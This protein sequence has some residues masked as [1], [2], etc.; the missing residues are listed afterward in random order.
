MFYNPL[1]Q[2]L[3]LCNRN[4]ELMGHLLIVRDQ[5]GTRIS[6][7]A[8][9]GGAAADKI[10]NSSLKD[11]A[12]SLVETTPSPKPRLLDL[13]SLIDNALGRIRPANARRDTVLVGRPLALVKADIG[14]ELFGK[15]WMDPNKPAVAREGTG[16][17][18]LNNLRVRV[19]LGYS[20]SVEDGL[21]G[22][23]KGNAYNHIVATQLPD[24]LK[25]SAYA[26]DPAADPLRIGFGAPE[27]LTLLM[28]PW[29]S[30]QA[31]CGI[32]PAKPI[33]IGR[34]QLDEIVMRMETSFRV[35]PVLLQADRVALPTPAVDKG[36]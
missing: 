34:A 26:K 15:A 1:D 9:A 23:F 4:G 31:A 5:R 16:D 2:A 35:G 14:L 11:F 7:E 6:W 20:H 19:N 33:T 3:V 12:R 30:V 13:L 36:S 24:E 29:G 17:A 27:Q 21:V 8:G 10:P 18:T 28:D 32:V 22:Y 25:P